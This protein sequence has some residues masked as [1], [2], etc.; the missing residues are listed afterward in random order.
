MAIQLNSDPKI[1]INGVELEGYLTDTTNN[2]KTK[3]H[4]YRLDN[5]LTFN[6]AVTNRMTAR[7]G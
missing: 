2:E 4:V 6:D 7:D 1:K 5:V 3:M